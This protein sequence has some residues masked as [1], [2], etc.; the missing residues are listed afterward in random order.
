MKSLG[1]NAVEWISR[2]LDGRDREAVLG[3]IAESGQPWHSAFRDILGLVVR[4]EAALWAGH[5]PWIILIAVV[6]PLGLLISVL[7]TLVSG[8]TRVYVWMYANNWDWALLRDLGFWR[9]FSEATVLA[10]IQYL[11][12]AC[13]A[14]TIGLVVGAVSGRV[15]RSSAF[16]M[17]LVLL[18]GGLSF[19]PRYLAFCWELRN[20]LFHVPNLPGTNDPVSANF[21]YRFAFPLI[22]QIGLVAL[23]ALRG[24]AAARRL[25]V[26][27]PLLRTCMWVAATATVMTLLVREPGL[28]L[29]FYRHSLSWLHGP[30][31]LLQIIAYWPIAY[32]L[33][34]KIKERMTTRVT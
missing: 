7:S 2:A 33:T 16:A 31:Y 6:V 25:R 14:W 19:A 34:T 11:T 13:C 12:L 5:R 17:L 10:C 4:R 20:A 27:G 30:V 18:A 21:F 26:S 28:S 23:P 29:L 1:W 22:V 24:I 9:I 32:L 15:F 8:E 3:D